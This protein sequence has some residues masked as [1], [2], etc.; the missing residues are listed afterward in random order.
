MET[1]VRTL[2][3][4]NPERGCRTRPTKP[5]IWSWRQLQPYS[6][7]MEMFVQTQPS[8]APRKILRVL[9]DVLTSNN[10]S[11]LRLRAAD[12]T[13]Q[14]PVASH[15]AVV[16]MLVVSSLCLR[17]TAKKTRECRSNPSMSMNIT[18]IR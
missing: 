4:L 15:L 2:L 11:Q 16:S 8:Q 14:S 5:L 7:S 9:H 17:V 6:T 1:C 12:R 13:M 18:P 3:Q 10:G